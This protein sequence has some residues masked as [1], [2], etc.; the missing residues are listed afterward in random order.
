M[1]SPSR[2]PNRVLSAGHKYTRQYAGPS[3]L[4]RL[5]APRTNA[6]S[7]AA[8]TLPGLPGRMMLT[9][10]ESGCGGPDLRIFECSKCGHVYKAPAEDRIKLVR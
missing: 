2:L 8:A 9:C 6:D 3:H 5:C 10:I 7:D 4:R 1:F